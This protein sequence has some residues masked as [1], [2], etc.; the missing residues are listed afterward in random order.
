MVRCSDIDQTAEDSQF[1]VM[2]VETRTND[3]W[4][5]LCLS[6]GLDKTPLSITD[7][8]SSLCVKASMNWKSDSEKVIAVNWKNAFL[9]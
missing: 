2:T 7:N 5:L 4:V 1:H 9:L 8:F 6:E 3:V